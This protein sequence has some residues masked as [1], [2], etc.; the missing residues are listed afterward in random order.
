[1]LGDGP[2]RHNW[3][4][5][6]REIHTRPCTGRSTALT[7]VEVDRLLWQPGW[8]L[9]AAEEFE[10]AHVKI[11]A[12]PS[13]L[14]EGLGRQ[15]SIRGHN[16]DRS[17]PLDA[18]LAGRRPAGRPSQGRLDHAPADAAEMPPTREL[19]RTIWEV[20][21]SIGTGRCRPPSNGVLLML[22]PAPISSR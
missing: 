2:D 21:R 12:E 15:E 4:R 22:L 3:Q 18:F 8:K 20:D 16:P 17:A 19:F 11:L 14:I 13:W 9:T 1:M 10:R 5:R 7:L 6:G